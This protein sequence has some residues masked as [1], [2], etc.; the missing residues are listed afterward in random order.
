MKNSCECKNTPNCEYKG[1][2]HYGPH[3]QGAKC[4]ECFCNRMEIRVECINTRKEKLLKLL[5]V[6]DEQI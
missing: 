3:D 4:E 1:C 6:Q 2:P 5:M